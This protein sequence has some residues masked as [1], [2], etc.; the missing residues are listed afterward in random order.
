MKLESMMERL[1]GNKSG[2]FLAVKVALRNTA[3]HRVDR[4]LDFFSSRPN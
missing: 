3:D 4:V 1:P 2:K